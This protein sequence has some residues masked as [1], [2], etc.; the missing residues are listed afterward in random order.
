M[1]PGGSYPGGPGFGTGAAPPED[2]EI[3]PLYVIAVVEV[4]NNPNLAAIANHTFVRI[5]HHWGSTILPDKREST[6]I[7]YGILTQ[8]NKPTA[9]IAKQFDA[10]LQQVRKEAKDGKPA[11]SDLI[12]L[13]EV[14]LN[15]GLLGDFTLMM[16]ELVK[17]DEKN[18]VAQAYT[19]LQKALAQPA[20]PNKDLAGWKSKLGIDNY[21][22]VEEDRT[23]PRETT[24]YSVLFTGPE[25]EAQNRLGLLEDSLHAFYYWFVLQGQVLP[26]PQERLL[27]IVLGQPE[28]L[29]PRTHEILGSVP[30]VADGFYARRDNLVVFA[31][32]PR[33]EAYKGLKQSIEDD[34][35]QT[36]ADTKQLLSARG[37]SH[38]LQT[39][40]LMLRAL[41]R[42]GEV[43]A[44][45]Q[46]AARQLL[47]AS[48]KLPRH[49]EV[50]EWVEFGTGSFFGTAKGS[51]WPS[52]AAP[53]T[54]LVDQNNYLSSYQVWSKGKKLDEP[55]LA[56]ERT[57]TDYYFRQAKASK[58]PMTIHKARTL[59]WALTFFLARQKLDGLLRYYKE[60]SKLPR[61]LEF[62]DKV[63][64]GCF[65]RAFELV[66]V[67]K[68]DTINKD[69]FAQF[70]NAWNDNIIMTP[71]DHSV[72]EVLL[73]LRKG[74]QSE[75]KSTGPPAPGAPGAVPPGG[76]G[77]APPGVLPP[78]PGG[79]PA[80]PP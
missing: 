31:G 74:G 71:L 30:L 11:A 44:I 65:A 18:Q 48:G 22:V 47:A 39:K 21:R 80:G 13:A 50:P 6:D 24:H 55:K 15:Y 66:E 53:C 61:D 7:Q 60:L 63:L 34:M 72:E 33:D 52:F 37:G 3:S 64:L 56:L 51:P 14:A 70:A 76:P 75:L 28:D 41:E 19:S 35:K 43:A 57:V 59:S 25:A 77:G 32:T 26:V 46:E 45:S 27:A 78:A 9:S 40:V 1:G 2:L 8:A 49:V 68:P 10:K 67:N 4:K 73:A 16:D 69:K 42:D 23:H 20:A 5:D 29:F 36:P 38:V 54:A 58:D 17:T 62:D 12:K 79:K